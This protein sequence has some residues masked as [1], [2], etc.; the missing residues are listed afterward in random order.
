MKKNYAYD[1][2]Y[3]IKKYENLK[4]QNDIIEKA[5]NDINYNLVVDFSKKYKIPHD[6]IKDIHRISYTAMNGK[7]VE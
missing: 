5:L 7:Y 4:K 3:W 6:L 2:C 1:V